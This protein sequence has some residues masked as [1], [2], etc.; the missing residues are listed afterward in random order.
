V[1]E[2]PPI[3]GDGERPGL[4]KT[5]SGKG[6]YQ[7]A[8]GLLRDG[9]LGFA[10]RP[11]CQHDG[12][13]ENR[14]DRHNDTPFIGYRRWHPSP[15]SLKMREVYVSCVIS[16]NVSERGRGRARPRSPIYRPQERS[17]SFCAPCCSPLSTRH[18]C[19]GP[20]L[21]SV[22]SLCRS[23]G[24]PCAT[25][26]PRARAHA[27]AAGGQ[28]SSQQN[29]DRMAQTLDDESPSHFARRLVRCVR[30]DTTIVRVG[31]LPKLPSQEGEPIR[32]SWSRSTLLSGTR[33]ILLAAIAL[34]VVVL[35]VRALVVDSDGPRR[36]KQIQ[37]ALAQSVSAQ[38]APAKYL[39]ASSSSA[40]SSPIRELSKRLR[41]SASS[42]GLFCRPSP[43]V[44]W[45]RAYRELP[46][47]TRTVTA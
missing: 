39:P 29:T 13:S 30:D 38:T 44:S 12:A 8:V 16:C 22:G 27:S 11:N 33:G 32:N 15:C 43:R 41:P 10:Y 19:S 36:S 45:T 17:L 31:S 7:G 34:L 24:V 18:L 26:A 1:S 5:L 35:F 4:Q 21:Q 42:C 14:K 40:N 23:L 3:G 47:S 6:V 37:F 20:S 9:H 25:A 2:L 28:F 46:D